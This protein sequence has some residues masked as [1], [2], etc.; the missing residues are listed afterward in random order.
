MNGPQSHFSTPFVQSRLAGSG[1]SKGRLRAS[2][3]NF[4]I[5]NSKAR[6]RLSALRTVRRPSK[7]FSVRN[8]SR[9]RINAPYLVYVFGTLHCMSRQQPKP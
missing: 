4:C 1:T 9:H 3:A 7:L 5:G 2:Y 8:S 6:F